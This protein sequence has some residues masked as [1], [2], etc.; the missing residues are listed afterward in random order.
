[1]PAIEVSIKIPVK[2]FTYKV[3]TKD[4]GNPYRLS[5]VVYP[6]QILLGLLKSSDTPFKKH[7]GTDV[8]ELIIPKYYF[9][10]YNLGIISDEKLSYFIEYINRQFRQKL[11]AFID[12][13]LTLAD[14]LKLNEKKLQVRI[15][16]T[17]Q[18][19]CKNYDLHEQEMTVDA[20]VKDY[21]RERLSGKNPHNKVLIKKTRTTSDRN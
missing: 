18:D 9:N 11:Y 16:H 3:F 6:G 7:L 15:D 10:Q 20:W 4:F 19:F 14:K 17:V 13:R 12:G 1:M 8:I 21:Y 2:S 5:S